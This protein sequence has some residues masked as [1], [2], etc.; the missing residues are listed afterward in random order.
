VLCT[1]WEDDSRSAN[2]EF[3]LLWLNSRMFTHVARRS[4]NWKLSIPFQTLTYFLKIHLNITLPFKPR[5]HKWYHPS[6]FSG[7]RFVCISNRSYAYCMPISLDL[8]TPIVKV[9]L[10]LYRPWRPLGLQEVE[11]PT[12]SDIRL[13]DG[14]KIVS[15]TRRPF[16][17][18]GRFLVRIYVRGWVDPRA[19]VRLEALGKLKKK[20]H[21]IRDSNRRP[22]GL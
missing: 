17:P 21:L 6:R 22:S 18:P 10:S 20:I 7:S 15:P 14:C 4:R 16:L 19:I 5:T 3:R 11:A 8:L 1:C 13:I 9:K 2:R 12:F